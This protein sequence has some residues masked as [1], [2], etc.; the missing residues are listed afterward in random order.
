MKKTAILLLSAISFLAGCASVALD[1]DGNPVKVASWFPKQIRESEILAANSFP[2]A[3]GVDYGYAYLGN[4]F[5]RSG[6]VHV[7]RIDLKK[8][9]VRPYVEEGSFRPKGQRFLKTTEAARKTGALFSLNGGFFCWKDNPEKKLKGQI[10][11][12]RM[13]LDGEIVE[14][15]AGGTL[16]LAFSSDGSKVKVGRVKDDELP[17]WENYMAGEGLHSGVTNFAGI[18]AELK[19]SERPD[20]PRTFLGMDPSGRYLYT[21]VT[22]GRLCGKR[23]SWGL[24]YQLSS[25]VGRW[26]GCSECI[27]MDG[28][29]SSTLVVRKSALEGVREPY[30]PEAK[31]CGD[32]VILNATSD[33]SERAVLDHIQFLDEKSVANPPRD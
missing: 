33:G 25:E 23:P 22:G 9:K 12:Y 20:A 11:Y 1:S 14:S 7:V 31:D 16:G 32:Y 30:T 13:K 19:I 18:R 28:G 17:D 2:I 27:N 3:K 29:G 10:P 8:A 26:F 4:L 24:S 5:G 6:D 15:I 21:F